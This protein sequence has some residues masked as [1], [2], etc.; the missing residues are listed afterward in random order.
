M[1]DVALA[2]TPKEKMRTHAAALDDA[3]SSRPAGEDGT[4]WAQMT[5]MVD[6]RAGPVCS[7]PRAGREAFSGGPGLALTAAGAPAWRA[8]APAP[9][10]AR[11]GALRYVALFWSAA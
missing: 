6:S 1:D 11:E 2:R 4:P 9:G 7:S 8:R 5:Q 10:G 3:F